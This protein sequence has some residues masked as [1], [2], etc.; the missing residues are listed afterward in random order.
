MAYAELDELETLVAAQKHEQVLTWI[1]EH[2]D[3]FPRRYYALLM[4]KL[5]ALEQLERYQEALKIVNEEL[6]M[7]YIPAPFN[8]ALPEI[9]KRL[10]QALRVPTLTNDQT[11][12]LL[13]TSDFAQQLE[14]LLTRYD[15]ELVLHELRERSLREV[16]PAIDRIF[17]QSL[18]PQTSK[19]L[20]LQTLVDLGVHETLHYLVDGY[21]VEIIPSELSS[22]DIDQVAR[23]IIDPLIDAIHQPSARY[24]FEAL[25][26][27]Y[28]IVHYPIVPE[29]DEYEPLQIALYRVMQ[30]E[31]SLAEYKQSMHRHERDEQII[32]LFVNELRQ[33]KQQQ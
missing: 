3:E 19:S 12:R 11:L 7:P 5:E 29:E 13:S 28:L 32:Q 31:L 15:L 1:D 16:L 14:S 23:T 9:Q 24:F 33:I 20:I 8:E 6:T 30:K 25:L 22:V 26:M 27:H 10:I 4:F 17:R 18:V 2:L 21:L